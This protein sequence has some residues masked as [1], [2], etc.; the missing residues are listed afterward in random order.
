MPHRLDV[1]EGETYRVESGEVQE[2]TGA[3]IDGT[4]QVDGTLRLVD[5]ADHGVETGTDPLDIPLGLDLP[6]QPLTLQTM[7]M[8]VAL[9]LVGTWG[10]LLGAAAFLKNYA[11][12]I[13]LFFAVMAALFSG[14]LGIGLEVHWVL[15]V[16]TCILLAM[17]MVVRWS[18]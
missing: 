3:D 5:D 2:Y 17:G 14:L 4:L 7:Q 10:L 12:G 9:F 13:A 16:V 11:A 8:G 1:D 15:I 18:Q 6:T